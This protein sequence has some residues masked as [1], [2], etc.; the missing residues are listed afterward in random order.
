M[1]CCTPTLRDKNLISLITQFAPELLPTGAAAIGLFSPYDDTDTFLIHYPP[2]STSYTNFQPIVLKGPTSFQYATAKLI[3]TA[4]PTGTIVLPT[5]F[6]FDFYIQLGTDS[7]SLPIPNSS[8]PVSFR[9]T[10]PAGTYNQVSEFILSVGS[11]FD[12]FEFPVQTF[13]LSGISMQQFNASLSLVVIAR[14]PADYVWGTDI[15]QRMFFSVSLYVG[16]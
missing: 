10:I 16:I 2:S 12:I 13:P 1:S 15:T 5:P 4:N 6:Y 3:I 11:Y 14:P 9:Y 8:T 7:L